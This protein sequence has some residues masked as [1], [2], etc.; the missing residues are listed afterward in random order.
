MMGKTLAAIEEV[1]KEVSAMP[2]ERG[3]QRRLR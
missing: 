2:D 3:S 1:E